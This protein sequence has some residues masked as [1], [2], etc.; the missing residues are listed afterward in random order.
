MSDMY[1]E[2]IRIVYLLRYLFGP[3]FSGRNTF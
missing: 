2:Q 1:E 3:K